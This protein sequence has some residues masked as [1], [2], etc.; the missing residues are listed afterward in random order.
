MTTGFVHSASARA[1]VN[2]FDISNFVTKI[3]PS[4]AQEMSDCTTLGETHRAYS[5]SL[6]SG[7]LSM[8]GLYR[9]ISLGTS[10]DGIFGTLPTT[11]QLVS[12]FP[13]GFTAGN[14]V[15][16]IYA[17]VTRYQVDNV[18][19][20]LVKCAIQCQAEQRAVERGVSLHDLTAETSF[21]VNST[22]VDNGSATANGGVAVLHVTAIA[23]AAP[24]VVYRVQH[25]TNA[26]TWVDLIV[27][28]ASVAPTFARSEVAAGTT[29]NRHLRITITEGGTTSSV[30]GLVAFSRR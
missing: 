3:S 27:F 8:E 5:P 20:D 2:E 12:G 10:L 13:E 19:G 29:V 7:T 21:P 22:A 28:A 24:N 15:Y 25:S 9:A 18:T 14:P 6:K 16:M 30:T 11:A 4:G 1:L 26:S 17:D 23:G